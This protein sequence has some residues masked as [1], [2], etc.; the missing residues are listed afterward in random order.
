MAKFDPDSSEV[1]P[2]PEAKRTTES[3]RGAQTPPDETARD[4][5]TATKTRWLAVLDMKVTRFLGL[6]A[7]ITFLLVQIV[8]LFSRSFTFADNYSGILALTFVMALGIWYMATRKLNLV[9]VVS[10][11]VVLDRLS[12]PIRRLL[13]TAWTILLLG[14]ILVF[15]GQCSQNPNMPIEN[16]FI[17]SLDT[18]WTWL[19]NFWRKLLWYFGWS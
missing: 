11:G 7:L 2:R 15:V 8:K 13:S 3:P 18:Y 1:N 19:G 9:G 5:K 17:V 12:K 6:W 10:A 14:F 16:I 4:P